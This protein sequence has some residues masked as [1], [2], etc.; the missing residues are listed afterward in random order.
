[1]LTGEIK[2]KEKERGMSFRKNKKQKIKHA[3]DTCH[4]KNLHGHSFLQTYY[5]I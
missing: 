1:M 2:K 4:I 5:T 3:G